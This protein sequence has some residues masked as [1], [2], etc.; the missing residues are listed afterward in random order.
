MNGRV[1][2]TTPRPCRCVRV[3]HVHGTNAAYNA[4]GC[5]CG[6]CRAAHSAHVKRIRL[7]RSRGVR[8][9]IDAAP[10]RD[11]LKDLTATMSITDVAAAT[12]VDP[13]GL[14]RILNGKAKHVWA[15]TAARV[16]AAKPAESVHAWVPV[17]GVRR[18]LQALIAIGWT[19]QQIA[20]RSGLSPQ[21][22]WQLLNTAA[23]VHVSTWRRVCAVYDALG[24]VLPTGASPAARAGITVARRTAAA[25]GW[26]SA[27]AWDDADLDNPKA[28]PRGVAAV[29]TPTTEGKESR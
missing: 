7:L 24:T 16:A 18:R 10:T 25:K 6:P 17:L 5:L 21:Q 22:V 13:A 14:R 1:V 12:G 3:R 15:K 20:K 26:V 23:K 27:L 2:D 11:R 19:Q 29:A 8:R 9:L 28:R 4:D